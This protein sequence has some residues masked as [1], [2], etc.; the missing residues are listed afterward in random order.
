MKGH[1]VGSIE[2]RSVRSEYFI[3][4]LSY[5]FSLVRIVVP[6]GFLV[7]RWSTD[8]ASFQIAL[9]FTS[10][11]KALGNNLLVKH[12]SFHHSHWSKF[13]SQPI[14]YNLFLTAYSL[15]PIPYRLFPT[16]YFW[17]PIAYPLFPIWVR[18]PSPSSFGLAI[19]MQETLSSGQL[20]S[21]ARGVSFFFHLT[22]HHMQ[23]SY[24]FALASQL[25]CISFPSFRQFSFLLFRC[26]YASL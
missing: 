26:V 4:H 16:A 3:A 6:P 13:P 1:V 2:G 9:N 7:F 19:Q 17:P 14:T 23:I 25:L 22:L 21:K 8:I 5:I 11:D 20:R 12:H 24:L 10:I 15:P 18:F